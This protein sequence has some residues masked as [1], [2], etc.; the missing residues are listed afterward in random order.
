MALETVTSVEHLRSA[1]ADARSA[2]RTIG[3]IPTMGALHAGHL[4]LIEAARR[5]GDFTIVSIF[6][7]PTQFGPGDDFDRYPRTLDADRAICDAA[8]AQVL[9]VP[10]HEDVYPK[11]DQTRV[12]PG[13]LADGLCGPFRPGHFEGVCTVVAKLFGLVQPDVAYFG[14][15]DAQQVAIIRRMVLDLRMPLRI[16][17][18]PIVRE[19]DGLAL[20][21]RNAYLE[22]DQRRRS[23]CLYQALT[24]G[25]DM[26]RAGESVNDAVAA[27]RE[28]LERTSGVSVD[29]V[30]VVDPDSLDPVTDTKSRLMVAGAIRIGSC[31][32][33]D[34]VLMDLSVDRE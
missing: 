27:M 20:S 6:V 22:P 8:A 18:C 21:S 25:R 23:L 4:S 10:Q 2:N 13:P 33:I 31:R 29:Y 24:T 16:E 14:Q 30:S 12:R 5:N 17:A 7:N 26:L 19:P 3:F 11:G 15:K 28:R 34:N 1:V 9:F 32:L